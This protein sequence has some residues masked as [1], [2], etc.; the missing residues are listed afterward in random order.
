MKLFI[1]LLMLFSL[2]SCTEDNNRLDLSTLPPEKASTEE[3]HTQN[4]KDSNQIG[5]LENRIKN[6]EEK[7]DLDAILQRGVIR[8]VAPR[9]DGADALPREGIPVSAYQDLAQTYATQ[10]GLSVIWIYVDSFADLIPTIASGQGDVIIT[11]M[12]VTDSRKKRV[13]FINPINKTSEIVIAKKPVSSIADIKSISVPAG[14]AYAESVLE[15]FGDD[16]PLFE[17]DS[18][19]SD[20]DVLELINAGKIQA[21]VFDAN[22]AD[23]LL[24]DYPNLHKGMIIKKNRAIAWSVRK[25]A[26]D[27]QESLNQFLVSHHLRASHQQLEKRS[28]AEIKK[29]GKLR[30]LTL[31]N[32]ASYF[33]WKGELM[34]FDYDLMQK[35]AS[36]NDLHLAVILKNDIDELM[37]ALQNGEGDIAAASI[38]QTKERESRGLKFSR[39]Y[40]KLPEQ[41]I[42]TDANITAIADLS[43]RQGGINPS[44]SYVNTVARLQESVADID[45][46]AF[47]GLTTEEIIDKVEVGEIDYTIVDGH[48]A[49]IEQAHSAK[50]K[51][52]SLDQDPTSI[53]WLVRDDQIDILNAANAFI[54]KE[55]R[56]LYYN[57]KFNKYFKNERKIKTY[58]EG[59]IVDGSGLSRYDDLVKTVSAKYGFDWRLITSQM[60]QESKFN[61]NAKSFAGALGLMQVMPRTAKEFGFSN[62]KNPAQGIEAGVTY[63]NWLRDRFPED[64]EVGERTFFMLAAYNAGPGHVR[65][66]RKLARKLGLD[67]NKWFDNTEKAML[68]LSK[69]EYYKKARF[70]YV[71]GSEP[72]TYVREIRQRYLGYIN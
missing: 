37:Q 26:V 17:L 54:K 53:G 15:A 38:T 35:F 68:L 4:S 34:G 7:G 13:R 33:M 39:P 71:R 47:P 50:L 64:L 49:K 21:S 30:M 32:P 19:L 9:Y 44:T 67:P 16:L 51:S 46:M 57:I 20:S 25:N 59:R 31:N 27:L 6:Y 24:L 72:V 55:Y 2:V 52:L 18:S 43:G 58:L 22:V 42:F 48:L 29:S 41:L 60:Y 70:G 10:Q 62:L 1:P 5:S 28:W 3:N 36:D 69:P 23:L 65:D 12:T 8:F 45:I 66:A 11:N 61:P 63:M 56:G 40:L 14:T